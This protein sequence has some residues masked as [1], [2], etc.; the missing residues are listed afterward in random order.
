MAPVPA[1][2][3][4]G[5]LFTVE[6]D[7]FAF[8]GLTGSVSSTKAGALATPPTRRFAPLISRSAPTTCTIPVP[9]MI[10]WVAIRIAVEM[11]I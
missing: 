10:S 1:R 6:P 2:P 9:N 7:P 5:V 11:I 3:E 8:D 4:Q